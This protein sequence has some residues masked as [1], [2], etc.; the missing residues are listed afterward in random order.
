MAEQSEKKVKAVAARFLAGKSILL[1]QDDDLKMKY[2]TIWEL[3][4]PTYTG[5]RCTRETGRLSIKVDGSY[6]RVTVEAP[7]ERVQTSILLSGLMTLFDDLEKAL[8]DP[9]TS[10][11]PC[12]EVVKKN[13][14]RVADQLDSHDENADT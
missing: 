2:P 9:A 10:W 5:T 4:M 7:T 13:K 11:T 8:R 14:P 6:Y 12:W 1:P 3:L